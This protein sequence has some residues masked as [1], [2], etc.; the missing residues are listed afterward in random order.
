[1]G[2]IIP[3]IALGAGVWLLLPAEETAPLI[4]Q[5]KGL[6]TSGKMASIWSAY[7]NIIKPLAEEFGIPISTCAAILSIE[8]SGNGFAKDGR[9]L[10]RFEPA[11]FKGF[12]GQVIPATHKN[13]QAE[14]DAFNAAKAIDE[15][16]A[17]KSISMGCGQIMGANYKMIGYNSVQDMYNDFNSGIAP[18]IRGFF[19][20]VKSAK[21]IDAAKNNDFL[22]FARKYN[23]PGQK[24]YDT[25]I[26]SAKDAFTKATG[27]V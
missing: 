2:P 14:W 17:L 6:T 7:G 10:I 5:V 23:G 24:G 4:S 3:L 11:Y 19:N 1:M 25:K 20:F 8:S 13:Q 16:A 27:I 9:L 12:T 15:T 18:Q 21:L 22:T 26:A